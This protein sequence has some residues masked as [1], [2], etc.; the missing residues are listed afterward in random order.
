MS[1]LHDAVNR[2]CPGWPVAEI[3]TF[4]YLP[5]GY[6]NDNYAFACDGERYVLRVPLQ[7]PHR[8]SGFIDRKLEEAFYRDA[9]DVRKVVLIAF[10]AT[11]GTMISRWQD[12]V[13]LAHEPPALAELVPYL[14]NLHRQLPRCTRDYD[15]LAQAREYLATGTPEPAIASL[16]AGLKWQPV[17]AAGCHNDLNPWN[18]IRATNSDWVTLDW[19]W[20]GNN[21][22]LFDL[23][24]LHQGLEL[25]P[26]TLAPLAAQFLAEPAAAERLQVCFTAYWLREYA[27]AHAEL[28]HGND[29]PEIRQQLTVSKE[30]LDAM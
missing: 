29:T 4:E 23:V 3:D 16:A 9:T 18:I 26:A 19:E 24:T 30:R 5:G 6:A 2:L 20:F 8:Q 22:P 7:Q 1:D 17:A 11:T 27:W 25:E 12:G 10:D 15:P 14:Q 28:Y 21:D 13:L